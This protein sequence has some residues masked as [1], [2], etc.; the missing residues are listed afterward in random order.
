[1]SVP[2]SFLF[3]L[4]KKDVHQ[5]FMMFWQYIVIPPNSWSFAISNHY[6]DRQF[7]YVKQQC[8]VNTFNI[9]FKMWCWYHSSYKQIFA[10]YNVELQSLSIKSVNHTSR[11]RH[12]EVGLRLRILDC[13]CRSCANDLL[14][15]LIMPLLF[16][17][18]RKSEL[19]FT[20]L[21][22]LSLIALSDSM[23]VIAT[24]YWETYCQVAVSV[25]VD[26]SNVYHESLPTRS[27]RVVV[28]VIDYR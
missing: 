12:S 8:N 21:S 17:A 1:V 10:M 19:S 24:R 28:V 2:I 27:A 16:D 23:L 25:S 22:A 13:R 5:N 14:H 6:W 15:I 26:M 9:G 20:P 7:M 3:L 4:L 18:D 11:C